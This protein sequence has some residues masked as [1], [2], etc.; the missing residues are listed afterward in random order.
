M[1]AEISQQLEECS[2]DECPTI[3]T[4]VHY[5]EIYNTF[6]AWNEDERLCPNMALQQTLAVARNRYGCRERGCILKAR[7]VDGRSLV[8]HLTSYEVPVRLVLYR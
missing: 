1:L 7:Y 3:A 6:C 2:I 4:S 8:S 5:V